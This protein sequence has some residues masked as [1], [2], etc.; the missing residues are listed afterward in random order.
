M[1]ARVCFLID[2]ELLFEDDKDG[3]A[4]APAPNIRKRLRAAPAALCFAFD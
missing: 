3:S 1:H 2:S 4:G